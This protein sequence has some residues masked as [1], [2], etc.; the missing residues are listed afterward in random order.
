MK[1]ALLSKLI[2]VNG[3]QDIPIEAGESNTSPEKKLLRRLS[4]LGQRSTGS[5]RLGDNISMGIMDR[6]SQINQKMKAS[7]IGKSGTSMI[8]QNQSI[9][10]KSVAGFE[11]GQGAHQSSF[12]ASA[13][14]KPEAEEEKA[15]LDTTR[16]KGAQF[17]KLTQQQASRYAKKFPF[18]R[19]QYH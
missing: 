4:R 15:I 6:L 19:G 11:L 7:K 18:E 8:S 10:E 14:Q 1:N 3:S 2:N 17:I 5:Q 12:F 9:A 16:L 13:R